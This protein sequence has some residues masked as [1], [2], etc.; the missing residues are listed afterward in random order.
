[1]L[2]VVA[3]S[4]GA[5]HAR[6]QVEQTK[7]GKRSAGVPN[8]VAGQR[9][10][11]RDLRWQSSG[12]TGWISPPASVHLCEAPSVDRG[13]HATR[14]R[15]YPTRPMAGRRAVGNGNRDFVTRKNSR[16]AVVPRTRGRAPAAGARP[17][18]PWVQGAAATGADT[19]SPTGSRAAPRARPRRALAPPARRGGR[20]PLR[21]AGQQKR[22]RGRKR[23]RISR[24]T[25]RRL[26]HF[27][28]PRPPS[29]PPPPRAAV[30]HRPADA[31][32]VG[33]VVGWRLPPS[34]H[35]TAATQ[36]LCG[37]ARL[38]AAPSPPPAA[39]VDAPTASPPSVRRRRPTR[40]PNFSRP[41]PPP[42]PTLCVLPS[43][44]EP[45]RPPPARH[46]HDG[47]RVATAGPP[48]RQA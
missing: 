34:P 39:T 48:P 38:G 7:C 8:F 5:T 35:S 25:G 13:R 24:T 18:D 15:R 33:A 30:P 40:R 19:A 6:P 9:N 28:G 36:C 2:D 47:G 10:R 37:H 43:I 41:H 46:P 31:L 44:A 4:T 26:I 29:S 11:P 3:P 21:C 17:R 32:A 20:R 12:R 45:A 23:G 16:R 1:M 14:A 42:S 27:S 22:P